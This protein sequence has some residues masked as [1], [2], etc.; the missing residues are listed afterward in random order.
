ML[1]RLFLSLLLVCTLPVMAQQQLE[2]EV[3]RGEKA[4]GH[5]YEV[6]ASGVV[7]A[8]PEAVW[9]ILTDYEKMPEFVPD[10]QVSRVLS[11]NGNLA[12]IEQF[13]EARFFFFR[14]AIHLVVQVNEQPMSLIDISLVSG[15]MKVY[16][17]SW[18]LVP[19]PE[20]G[21]TRINYK[22]KMIP[23]FFVPG[24]MGANIIRSDI[25]RMM[26]AVLERLD[27]PPVQAE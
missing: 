25:Q 10:L 2:V 12:T 21:G 5:A 9:K 14:R 18:E 20:T 8:S 24:M 13:G 3:H 17:C 19:V 11:R 4:E 15:D 6:T 22:G 16:R 23:K 1:A 26:R 7:R 27:R